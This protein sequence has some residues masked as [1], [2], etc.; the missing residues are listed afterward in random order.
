M[1]VGI[2][3]GKDEDFAGEPFVGKS[4]ILL[5]SMLKD[6]GYDRNECR[7]TNAVRCIPE[8]TPRGELL[9]PTPESIRACKGYLI[10]EIAQARPQAIVA[11]GGVALHALTGVAGISNGRGRDFPLHTSYGFPCKVY[12]A[13][14]PAFV[15][16]EP[17]RRATCVSDLRRARDAQTPQAAIPWAYAPAK[18]T[19]IRTALNLALVQG[20][21]IAYDI[22][23]FDEQSQ[24]TDATTQMAIATDAGALVYRGGPYPVSLEPAT[25]ISHFGW[26]FDDLL[27]GIR[28]DYDT[29]AMAYLD[30]ETQPLGLEA[31]CVKYLGVRGWKE[32]RDAPLG[33]DALAEY[34]ARDAWY[35][36][37]FFRVI[38]ERL[39][40]AITQNGVTFRRIDIMHYI[41]RPMRYAL[42][43]ASD[44]GVFLDAAAIER[45]RVEQE[46]RI[47]QTHAAVIDALYATGFPRNFFD[48]ALKTKTRTVEFKPGSN[49]H[50]G[51]ALT[52]LG[53]TLQKTP[54]S[55]KWCVDKEAL[56]YIDHPFVDA[57][58][59][60]REA[61]KLKST[62][63]VPYGRLATTGDNRSHT[64]YK[65]SRTRTGRSSSS[66]PQA[67]PWKDRGRND[68][69][70]VRQYKHFHAA[71]PGHVLVAVDYASIEF[72]VGA[73]LAGEQTVLANYA[74]DPLWDP[75]GWFACRLYDK[76]LD[77]IKAE[78]EEKKAEGASDSM[79]QIA[80]SANFSQLFLGTG[81]TLRSYAARQMGFHISHAE[82][83]RTHLAWH[84]AF[85]GW[86]SWYARVK[87]ELIE[88]G[89]VQ[90]K[91]GRRRHFDRAWTDAEGRKMPP[92][93]L[94]NQ[95]Q[96]REALGEAVNFL[97]QGFCFDV[98]GIAGGALHGLKLPIVLFVH[99]AFY[100]EFPSMAEAK[101]RE[102]EIRH[103]MIDI[104]LRTLREKFGVEVGVPLEIDFIY[105][106]Y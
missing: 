2:A 13:W 64:Q 12:A 3:P 11:L 27:T 34:N 5:M 70:L 46:A 14:H 68:Q 61:T 8:V 40:E 74:Q 97:D 100:F 15:L 79:R 45:A 43:A 25:V 17:I 30:D 103:C 105:K 1:F 84:A 22:E 62:Y 67:G 92:L 94:M 91:T 90:S 4:G 29:A 77:E 72:R 65:I 76:T 83:H 82:A 89:Y 31:L 33:T 66:N 69:N 80:K 98:A 88:N 23:T 42:T 56:S 59:Q 18:G 24:I 21:E 86:L 93:H 99:D 87:E 41:A 38:W 78:H 53:Y 58:T 71:P 26:E 102:V 95:K 50:V 81:E 48:V 73:W 20:G 60:W 37:K 9:D 16:R 47:E 54:K 63:I 35:T 96:K 28:T 36:L 19:E 55:G 85:P 6:A 51:E 106:Q 10:D 101:T 52:W 7:F 32:D 39:Q 104:P 75:H 49:D 44:R 57:L